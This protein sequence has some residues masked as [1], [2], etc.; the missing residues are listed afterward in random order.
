M[1]EE[2]K[3]LEKYAEE[4]NIPIIEKSSLRFIQKYIK[5]NNVKTILEIGSAIGYSAIN[6][7]L[8]DEGISITTIEKDDYRYLEALKNIKTFHLEDRI[9]L[10][11]AD[12]L[13]IDIDGKFDLIFIDA[14]KGQYKNYFEKYCNKL[15]RNG[16]I[17]SDNISFHGLVESKEKIEKKNLRKLVDKIKDYIE[18]IKG[19]D[20]FITKFYKVGDGLSVSTRKNE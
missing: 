13:N 18:F 4:Y 19:H 8:V 17:I 1:I 2:M 16:T 6:M 5:E 10:L 11:L 14:A 3:A 9:T 15:N 7:A 12:A 20:G